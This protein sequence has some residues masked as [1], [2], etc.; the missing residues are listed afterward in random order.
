MIH[1]GVTQP[2]VMSFKIL[3][4]DI[5]QVKCRWDDELCDDFCR[6]WSEIFY[7]V[8]R[9]GK[10][11]ITRHKSMGMTLFR[12]SCMDLVTQVKKRMER[13]SSYPPSTNQERLMLFC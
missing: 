8:R 3:F 12:G 1:W 2:I 7:T 6:R 11:E 10:V 13:A 4:Q 5:C 9:F